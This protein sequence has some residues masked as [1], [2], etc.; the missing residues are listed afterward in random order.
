MSSYK[1]KAS[2]QVEAFSVFGK[3]GLSKSGSY[4]TT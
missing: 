1:T 4:A 2:T 3:I